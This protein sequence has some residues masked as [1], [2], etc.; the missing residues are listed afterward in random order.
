MTM[1]PDIL[2][3][4]D[5]S[6]LGGRT[7]EVRWS[8]VL[9]PARGDTPAEGRQGPERRAAFVLTLQ[10]VDEEHA[11]LEGWLETPAGMRNV[12]ARQPVGWEVSG[13]GDLIHVDAR[14]DGARVLA[15]SCA[16]ADGGSLYARC[17][18]LGQA[19]FAPGRYDPPTARLVRP[20]ADVA[21]G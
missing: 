6:V 13:D 3:D 4:D 16:P 1:S 19:G 17:A 14:I 20:E 12:V 11:L 2:V 10:P 8:A 5:A 18:L 21:A 9:A 7:I 15:L